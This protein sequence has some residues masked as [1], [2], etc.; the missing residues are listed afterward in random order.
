MPNMLLELLLGGVS[1]EIDA[2]GLDTH[3]GA[4]PVLPADIRMRTRIVTNEDRCQPE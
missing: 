1:R 3:L 2:N 4:V